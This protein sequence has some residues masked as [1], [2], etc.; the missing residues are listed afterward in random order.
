ME[1]SCLSDGEISPSTFHNGSD[2]QVVFTTN[3]ILKHS[4]QVETKLILDEKLNVKAI[5]WLKENSAEIW[6]RLNNTGNYY[7]YVYTIQIANVTFYFKPPIRVPPSAW[8]E[9][10]LI[11]AGGEGLF[12]WGVHY[13]GNVY[14]TPPPELSMLEIGMTYNVSVRTMTNNLYN[15]NITI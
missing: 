1:W 15:T 8:R 7:S 5:R 6:V 12:G 9:M 4:F 13:Y 14:A 11:F 3:G 10:R 2:Y